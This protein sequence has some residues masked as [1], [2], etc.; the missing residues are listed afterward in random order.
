LQ[1]SS[2]PREINGGTRN[3]TRRETSRHFRN[4]KRKYLKGKIDE[5][6]KNSRNKNI[7]DLYKGINDFKGGYQPRSNLVK[8]ENDDLL[9]DSH[10][11]L[12]RCKN[13][14]PQLLT[15]HGVSDVRQIEIHSAEQLV[16]DPSSHEFE[17][18]IA[19]FESYKWRGSG[20]IPA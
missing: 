10:N 7:R 17:T 13:L 11:I 3:N 5:L 9:A 15:V 18:A 16:P 4:K 1:W 2:D 14:F 19:M 12:N 8:D 6:A 20:Q